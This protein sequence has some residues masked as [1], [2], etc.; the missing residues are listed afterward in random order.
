MVEGLG[1]LGYPFDGGCCW[2]GGGFDHLGALDSLALPAFCLHSGGAFVHLDLAVHVL[3]QLG[4]AGD[5]LLGGILPQGL[6]LH[7][8]EVGHLF[9]LK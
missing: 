3:G 6:A 1:P 2:C 5:R 4:Q 7:E 9:A 8:A